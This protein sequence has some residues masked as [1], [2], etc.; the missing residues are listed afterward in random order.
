MAI[1]KFPTLLEVVVHRVPVVKLLIQQVLFAKL[2]Y[3]PCQTV[4]LVPLTTYAQH[5]AIIKFP[6]LVETA[7]HRVPVAKLL[8]QQEMAV[9]FVHPLIQ[10]A[11]HALTITLVLA[12]MIRLLVLFHLNKFQLLLEPV[13]VVALHS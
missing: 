10:T 11:M 12:V 1:I 6:F 7:V 8:I 2:V 13:V 9:S 4:L 5:A 3:L